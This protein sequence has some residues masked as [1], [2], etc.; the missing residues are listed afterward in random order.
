MAT[1]E[2]FL[3]D[4]LAF[5]SGWDRD[6]YDAGIIQDWQLDQW[7]GGTVEEFFPGYTSWS[8]L[9]DAEWEAMAYTSTNSFGFVGYQFGEALLIDLGYYDDDVYYG[10]GAATNTWDGTWT[11]KNGADSLDAFKT[12]EV[13][14]QAIRDAFGFNL[15]QM[16]AL[17]APYGKT[18]EDFIGNTFQYYDDNGQLAE[19]TITLTGLLAGAH[20]RGYP[21]AVEWLL[22]GTP[23]SDEYGTPIEQYV[24]Q[25]G[26]YDSP[27]VSEMIT[28][29][30][31]G[32]TGDEGLGTPGDGTDV[33]YGNGTAGVTAETADVV[34]TWN[35]GAH[36]VVD[37]FDPAN[38]TIFID[39]FT[40]AD[41]SV[42]EV[43]GSTVFSMPDNDN[44]TVT[45]Q[46][47]ALAELSAANFTIMDSSL[48]AEI[49]GAISAAPPVDDGSGAT[50]GD[51]SGGDGAGDGTTGDGAGDGG[52]SGGTGS[53]AVSDNGTAHVTKA[54]ASVVVTWAWGHDTV[55][56][57]FDP[58][59]DTIFVDWFQSGEV[60]VSE[61]EGDVVFAVPGNNHTVTLTDVTLAELSPAN[62]TIMDGNLG[63]EILSAVG[64]GTADGGVDGG[65]DGGDDGGTPGDTTDPGTGDTGGTTGGAAADGV[66]DVHH[67]TWN[68]GATELISDFAPSEDVLD[69]GA[70]SASNLTI[71]EVDGNLVFEVVNNGGHVYVLEGV[72]AEDLSAAN[73][74]APTW[75]GVLEA[76][77]GV[78]DQL[79]ALGYHDLLV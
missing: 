33:A 76:P 34:I 4:L 70:L 64:S 17:L 42:S 16:N 1:F 23:S 15:E 22:N 14:D 10:N 40:A 51:N 67:L 45:L 20:L 11:G 59:S 79:A 38:D 57:D 9:T 36:T 77:N 65:A 50:T 43:G 74:T 25:F 52:T 60:T 8:Q 31:D 69:L 6:R 32:R 2:D 7:A 24:V 21:A 28:Y 29:F 75:N 47:V 68:W 62:F 46:G 5:E 48:A 41:V 13:Q 66:V 73:F 26:G 44:Q 39:W 3:D 63:A 55:V 58:A 35:W 71:S 61:I 53:D 54:D 27:T 37:D 19:G 18:V 12:Q 78:F 56:T 72:Q 49:F 30:E